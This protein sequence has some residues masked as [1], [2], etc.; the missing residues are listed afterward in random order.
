VFW[1]ENPRLNRDEHEELLRAIDTLRL[2]QV[3]MLKAILAA[4]QTLAKLLLQ[5]STEPEELT[6]LERAA[7]HGLPASMADLV[8]WEQVK[9]RR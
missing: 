3:E 8:D 9:G 6:N 5:K 4:N 7:L 1:F 2:Q